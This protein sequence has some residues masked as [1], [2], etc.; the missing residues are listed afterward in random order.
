MIGRVD[1]KAGMKVA[2]DGMSFLRNSRAFKNGLE[3]LKE[4]QVTLMMDLG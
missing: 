1:L 3:E 4:R 2:F